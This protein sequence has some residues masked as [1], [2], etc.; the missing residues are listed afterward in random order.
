MT[1]YLEKRRDLGDIY[2][3]SL[4]CA[5]FFASLVVVVLMVNDI[6]TNHS[7]WM[8]GKA[9][10]YVLHGVSHAT[11]SALAWFLALISVDK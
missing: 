5:D 2:I 3:L 4:A 1:G 7:A 6:I 9:L 8:F 10:F 11:T